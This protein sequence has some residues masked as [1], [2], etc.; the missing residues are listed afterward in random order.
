M[1][2][3][4]IKR[5]CITCNIVFATILSY[6]K[7]GGGKYCSYTCSYKGR[8]TG[9]IINCIVCNKKLWVFNFWIKQGR[10]KYCSNKCKGILMKTSRLGKKNPMWKGNKVGYG[11]LHDWV[12]WWLPKT[13]L[14][15]ECKLVSPYDLANISQKYRRD[16]SDWEWLCR[17]C[18]MKK[19]GRLDKLIKMNTK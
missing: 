16:L 4:R 18:H 17:R 8:K 5:S 19:D 1:N 14:C 12:K 9:K 7:R 15:Q 2:R 10:G 6:I 11:A 13:K 3:N